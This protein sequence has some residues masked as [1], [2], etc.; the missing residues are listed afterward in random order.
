MSSIP[1]VDKLAAS[2]SGWIIRRLCFMAGMIL[3]V[4]TKETD[5]L[6]EEG[7]GSKS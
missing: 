2:F 3:C 1:R 4:E 7:I 5:G 6:Q